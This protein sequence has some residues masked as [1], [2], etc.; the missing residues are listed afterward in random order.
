M[1]T[2]LNAKVELSWLVDALTEKIDA[3]DTSEKERSLCM[4]RRTL[5]INLLDLIRNDRPATEAC[6]EL[7]RERTQVEAERER[8]RAEMKYD[9]ESLMEFFLQKK[10]VSA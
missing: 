4:R 10:T 9:R 3:P 2:D 6:V 7:R 5:I 8:L 1:E